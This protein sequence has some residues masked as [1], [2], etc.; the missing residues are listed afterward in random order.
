LI[1]ISKV[2]FKIRKIKTKGIILFLIE[3]KKQIKE[4]HIR[5]KQVLII[6]GWEY[7]RLW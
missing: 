2:P 3:M 5:K 1:E 4:L 7:K 6:A